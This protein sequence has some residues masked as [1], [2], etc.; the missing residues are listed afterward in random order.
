MRFH[1]SPS[2]TIIKAANVFPVVQVHNEITF[3]RFY[4]S[5]KRI[6]IEFKNILK[7]SKIHAYH[8]NQSFEI[9]LQKMKPEH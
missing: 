4:D 6:R 1:D 7:F 3:V 9:I 5:F 2:I 8:T